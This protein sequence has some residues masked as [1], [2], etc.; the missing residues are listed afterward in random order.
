MQIEIVA[1]FYF[2]IP[3]W[4]AYEGPWACYS[5]VYVALTC[6]ATTDFF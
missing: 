2:P 3:V 5:A 1:D 4:T 6:E